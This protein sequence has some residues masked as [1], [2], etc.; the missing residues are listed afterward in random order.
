[1]WV[2]SGS[3]WD[4]EL[5]ICTEVVELNQFSQVSR[6]TNIFLRNIDAENAISFRSSTSYTIFVIISLRT[7]SL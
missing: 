4:W 1:L 5:S 3:K 2:R 7:L 6:E